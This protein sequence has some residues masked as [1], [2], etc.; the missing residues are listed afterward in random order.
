MRHLPPRRIAAIAAAVALSSAAAASANDGGGRTQ[1]RVR[2]ACTGAT[3][4]KL[5][6]RAERE[7][8]RIDFELRARPGARWTVIVL[9]ERQTIARWTYRRLAGGGALELRREVADWYGT[10]HIAVRAAGPR[11][12]SCRASAVV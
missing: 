5:R 7:R 4:A 11:G 8:I 3:E 12:E 6:V 1:V 9:H 10:D 2:A